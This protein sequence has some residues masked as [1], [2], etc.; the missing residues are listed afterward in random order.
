MINCPL[1]QRN[2]KWHCPQCGWSYHKQVRRNC[3]NARATMIAEFD[4]LMDLGD[5][6]AADKI[7]NTLLCF[8]QRK[9]SSRKPCGSK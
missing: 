2:G 6:D 4:R 5:D 9:T 3:P 8:E 1:E 7:A